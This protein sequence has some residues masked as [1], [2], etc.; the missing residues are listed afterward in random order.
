M[1]RDVPLWSFAEVTDTSD[2]QRLV[3]LTGDAEVKI[4]ALIKLARMSYAPLYW[5][6][7]QGVILTHPSMQAR[8][9]RLAKLGAVSP[10]RL[11]ELVALLL[12]EAAYPVAGFEESPHR[13]NELLFSTKWKHACAQR[14]SWV[15]RLVRIALPLLALQ[16]I[17]WSTMQQNPIGFSRWTLLV[18]MLALIPL[19]TLLNDWIGLVW[20][21][22]EQRRLGRRLAARR[23]LPG[24][25]VGLAPGATV[26]LFEGFDDWDMGLLEMVPGQIIYRGERTHFVVDAEMI[27]SIELMKGLPGWITSRRIRVAWRNDLA[28]TDGVFHLGS[29]EGTARALHRELL[30]WREGPSKAAEDLARLAAGP[31]TWSGIVLPLP[32][33]GEVTS[34]A[35]RDVIRWSG[36]LGGM[37]G[38]FLLT[39]IVA[40]ATGQVIAPMAAFIAP[41]IY[42]AERLPILLSRRHPLA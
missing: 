18:P 9:E 21:Y 30:A 10:E 41:L 16:G 8:I 23:G 6:K 34:A 12:D 3:M 24:T 1:E 14:Q 17:W 39:L 13:E 28:G 22:Q 27:Q 11:A 31:Q 29:Y 32:R 38:T 15:T 33:F 19:A 20:G 40:M 25:V 42:G 4:S 35:P 7:A 36:V 37:G 5:S 26:R 2:Y